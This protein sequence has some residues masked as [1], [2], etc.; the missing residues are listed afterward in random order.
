MTAVAAP[1]S[2]TAPR[3]DEPADD[4]DALAEAGR[5]LVAEG[6]RVQRLG[7]EQADHEPDGEER[8]HL[9]EARERAAAHAAD[10]PRADVRRDVAAGQRDGGDERGERGRGRGPGQRQLEG[11]GASSSE[12]PDR[13][14]EQA[15]ATAAPTI[16]TQ[17]MLVAALRP[18][19]ARPVTTARE[20]PVVDPED[21]R[22]GQRVARHALHHGPGDGEGG[23]GGDREQ[24]AGDPLRDGGAVESVGRASQCG[25]HV[26]ERHR[27]AS[28]SSATAP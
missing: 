27:R 25:E 28:R 3:A 19:N 5:E 6:Q 17:T 24:G 26:V 20:A 12:R 10:L 9:A 22:V 8:Q 16:A 15:A 7:R 18:K 14:D 2:T 11:R 21:P 13:V 23:S 1:Q 4:R